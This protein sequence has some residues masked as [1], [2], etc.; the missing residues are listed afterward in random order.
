MPFHDWYS[1]FEIKSKRRHIKYVIQRLNKNVHLTDFVFLPGD[2]LK[3]QMEHG[4][5]EMKALSGTLLSRLMNLTPT[6]L[7]P[8][9]T[10]RHSASSVLE[11]EA[12]PQFYLYRER[13]ERSRSADD[14]HV[15]EV[16][17]PTW[18]PRPLKRQLSLPPK[19]HP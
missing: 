8:E 11:Y 10:R 5:I 19:I 2:P 9:R 13:L 7:V 4:S 18:A 1:N 16:L 3:T 17:D 14:V 6:N 15:V 12:E